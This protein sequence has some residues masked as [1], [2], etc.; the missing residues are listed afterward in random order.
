MEQLAHYREM[1]LKVE[2]PKLYNVVEA[3][4]RVP[5]WTWMAKGLAESTQVGRVS[6]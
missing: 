1:E 4:C 5:V 3:S 2:G 6:Q